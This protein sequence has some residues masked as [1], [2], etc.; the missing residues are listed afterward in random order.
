MKHAAYLSEASGPAMTIRPNLPPDAI[1]AC[2]CARACRPG[3]DCLRGALDQHKLVFAHW[4]ASREEAAALKQDWRAI[5][6]QP[7]TAAGA[8]MHI[9]RDEVPSGGLPE[10]ESSSTETGADRWAAQKRSARD[11]VAGT[12][13]SLPPTTNHRH[14]PHATQPEICQRRASAGRFQR[15]SR[16]LQDMRHAKHG[17]T[18]P[19]P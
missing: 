4:H 13:S 12:E 7:R 17:I 6:Q 1:F 15:F 16:R 5:R 14:T 2:A 9:P 3:V 10:R 18:A 19:H 8:C 11:T